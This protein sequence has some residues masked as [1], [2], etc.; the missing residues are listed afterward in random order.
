MPVNVTAVL[1]ALVLTERLSVK[2]D[3][4][5]VVGENMTVKEVLAPGASV[6]PAATDTA[7]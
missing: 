6:P 2:G 1:P 4:T 3:P 5:V 7:P